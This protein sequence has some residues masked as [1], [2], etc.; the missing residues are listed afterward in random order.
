MNWTSLHDFLHMGGYGGYVW[1]AFA[2]TAG[3]IAIE[4]LGL[5]ARSRLLRARLRRKAP[6]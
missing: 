1:T 2:S 3:A 5:A 4:L 6:A